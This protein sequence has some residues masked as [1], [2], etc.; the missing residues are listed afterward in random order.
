MPRRSNT[1]ARAMAVL[2]YLAAH[3]HDTFGLTELATELSV[4]KA[5][6]LSIVTTLRDGGWILQHP[7][8]RT[9]SLGPTIIGAG[10][11]AMSRFPNTE[12]IVPLMVD[13]AKQFD[14]ACLAVTV[15]GGQMVVL[16]RVGF[17]DPFHGLARIGARLLFAPP[18]G[19]SLAAWYPP[20]LFEQWM[21]AASPPLDHHE[22]AEVRRW[23]R[24]A[25]EHG[26]VIGRDLP[27]NDRLG[28]TLNDLRVAAPGVDHEVL[29]E[30]ARASRAA[31]YYLGLPERDSEYRVNHVS[32]PIRA[33]TA[34]PT[35]AL[36]IPLFGKPQ[37]GEVVLA[38]G[39]ALS[40]TG[41]RAAKILDP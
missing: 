28:R 11:A 36:Y 23:V 30:F 19:L 26:F 37:R 10:H 41:R 21:A 2:E 33:P 17:V 3:P 27:E 4:N 38:M 9:Y 39:E 32:A 7:I 18:F 22:V 1:T 6:M 15:A 14:V 35:I 31:G 13:I 8:R 25:H 40:D 29:G 12:P 20:E 34:V 24:F 5:T 16:N